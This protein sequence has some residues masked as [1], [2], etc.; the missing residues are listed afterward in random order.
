MLS[1][2]LLLVPKAF[3]SDMDKELKQA[4]KKSFPD[5]SFKVD[6]SFVTGK[7]T[8]LPL[9]PIKE[10]KKQEAEKQRNK[11]AKK[12]PPEK[13]EVIQALED[14]SG[15]KLL[16]LSGGW[17][18]VK[19]I[20]EKD[21]TKTII[22]LEEIPVKY[23]ESFLNAR[24]PA[25]LVV[26]K[27]FFIEEELSG[28]IGNLPIKVKGKGQTQ[29]KAT[30]AKEN[31]QTTVSG[32]LYLTSPDTGKI[33]YLDLNNLSDINY[34]ETEGTPWELSYETQNKLIYVTDLTKD[35]IHQIKLKEKTILKSLDLT[36]MSSPKNVDISEDGS[37]LYLIEGIGN[38]FSVLKTSDSKF[39]TKVKVPPNPASFAISKHE[40]LIAI[41]CPNTNDLVFLKL[42]D[43]SVYDRMKIEGGIEKVIFGPVSTDLYILGRND[44]SVIVVDIKS[45][46]I[47]NKFKV[48]ETPVS[49]VTDPGERFLYVG[50]G[51][52]NT[53]S[54]IDLKT[55]K[56]KEEIRL[57]VETQ[58]PGDLEITKD[59]VWLIATSETTNTISIIDLS[60]RQIAIKLDVGATTHAAYLVDREP[61]D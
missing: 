1:L 13:V 58:F 20:E 15:P 46:K 39:F 59:G 47:K 14:K 12:K 49:L 25:D 7:S 5:I 52:S 51:K 21:S 2:I 4:L 6:N 28:L 29:T 53:I 43:F 38:N 57:P 32:L 19:V 35:V 37:V 18:Y 3:C 26:P 30:A 48:G 11:E 50:C 8:F 36:S 16:I 42:D 61:E 17:F 27:N 56:V 31:Y 24:F 33:V 41:T 54:V 9:I 10:T 34:I 60:M 55:N 45:R 23:R 40:N 22:G 44:N